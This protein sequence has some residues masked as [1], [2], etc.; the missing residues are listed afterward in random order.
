MIVNLVFF[1]IVTLIV[2]LATTFLYT[3]LDKWGLWEYLI[4][5]ADSWVIKVIKKDSDILSRLFSCSFCTMWWMSLLICICLAI[6]SGEIILVLV[7]VC[8]VPLSRAFLV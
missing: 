2:S 8:S 1:L 7:P 3:L 6:I 5:H 4:V